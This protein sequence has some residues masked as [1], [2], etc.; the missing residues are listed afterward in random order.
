[1]SM[2]VKKFGWEF[3]DKLSELKP[4]V[5]QSAVDTTTYLVRGEADITSGTASYNLF[6]AIKKGEKVKML[7]PKEGVPFVVSPQAIFKSA[8]HPNAAK[9]FADWLFSKDAQQILVDRGLYVGHPG[10][11]YP[12]GQVPL[13]ELKLMTMSPEEATKMRNPIRD[14]FRKKFGV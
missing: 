1:M 14:A 10:V 3:M 4:R 12:D 6:N 5:V 8:P 13:K 11:K 9:I 2:L 7:L